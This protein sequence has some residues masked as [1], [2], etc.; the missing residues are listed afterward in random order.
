MPVITPGVECSEVRFFQPDDIPWDNLFYPA[1]GDLLQR[2]KA[3]LAAGR[4]TLYTGTSVKGRVT[5]IDR[6]EIQ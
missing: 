2:Y 1:I 6:D 5:S 3:D 4:F